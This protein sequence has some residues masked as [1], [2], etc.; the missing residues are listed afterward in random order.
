MN[1]PPFLTVMRHRANWPLRFIAATLILAG[2]GRKEAVSLRSAAPPAEATA[3]DSHDL[4]GE[5]LRVDPVRQ[6]LVVHHEEISSYMPAMTMEFTLGGGIGV[7]SFREGQRIAARFVHAVPG[8]LRLDAIR[9]LDSQKE[10]DLAAATLALRQDTHTRGKHAY[11]EI[12][13]T[14][15]SFALYNQDGEIVRFDRFRGKHVVLNFIFTRWPVPTMCP[16]AT[17][18][19]TSLQAAA[20]KAGVSDLELVSISF[21]SAYDTPPVLKAYAAARGIDTTNFS[22]L[23]GPE[24]AIADLLRQFGVISI[25]AENLFRHTLAT[26]LI[27]PD[28][29]TLHRTD[30]SDWQP[31][32]FLRRLGASPP[33]PGG[34]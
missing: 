18:K 33:S 20:K 15:P 28:G 14:A 16:A 32:D 6:I 3:A 21:D 12:G 23:T 29:K 17:A 27:G 9:V 34:L 2:C 10:T 31:E 7:A 11:R 5:I 22:F 30:E 8:E 24:T 4:R 26:I 19:M 1:A 13:E 25:P